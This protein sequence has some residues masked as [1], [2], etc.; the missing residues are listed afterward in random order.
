MILEVVLYR[1][2]YKK[3]N[4]DKLVIKLAKEAVDM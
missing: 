1:K 4:D 2:D 3:V